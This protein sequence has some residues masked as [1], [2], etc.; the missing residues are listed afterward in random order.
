M[1]NRIY[2]FLFLATLCPNIRGQGREKLITGKITYVAL[3]NIYVK[4][5]STE[6]IQIGDTLKFINQATPCLLVKNKS[7]K[8]L[9]CTSIFNCK[10][11]SGDVVYF[12]FKPDAIKKTTPEITEVAVEKQI[13]EPVKTEKSNHKYEQYIN[14]KISVASYSSIFKESDNKQRMM[15]N[16]SLTADHFNNSKFSV[17][18]YLNYRQSLINNS[19]NSSNYNVFRAYTLAMKYDIDPTF[20][21][22]IGRTTNINIS[23]IGAIDGLQVEKYFGNFYVGVIGG[24]RPDI[25]DYNFNSNLLEYGG[26]GGVVTNSKNFYSQTTLGA[27]EQTYNGN[28]DR[29]YIYFQHSSTLLNK[30]NLFTSFELDIYSKINDVTINQ[31]RLTNL[32]AS[33]RYRFSK[34]VDFTL[35]YDTRKR[36]LYYETFQTEIER[37]LDDDEARQGFRGKLNIRPVK[38]IMAS[39]SYGKRFQNDGLNKADNLYGYIGWSKIPAIGGSLS[40]NYNNN[41]SNYL[42]SNVFSIR[43]SRTFFNNKLNADF[44]YR[45]ADYTYFSNNTASKLQFYGADFSVNINKTLRFSLFGEVSTGDQDNYRI[46]AVL[47]QRF[48]NRKK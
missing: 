16:F 19:S 10:V 35:S 25:Y 33:A 5:E 40:V 26:Y 12:Y 36:I 34:K 28:T 14:G 44:Y 8:S 13:P 31:T 48:K 11:K 47:I 17:E 27:I 15:Y 38:N 46:N 1:K 18:T 30:L 20:S 9:V 45:F 29:R 39:F 42:E 32:Y 21:A 37:L 3:D 4:F 7:S 41:N 6:H 24:F 2:L 23:S 43:H 22:V